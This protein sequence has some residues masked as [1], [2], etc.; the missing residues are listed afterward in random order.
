MKL[1]P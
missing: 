1:N